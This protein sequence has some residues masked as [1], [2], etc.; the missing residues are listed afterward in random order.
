MAH[1]ALLRQKAVARQQGLHRGRL[2]VAAARAQASAGTWWHG[3]A[4]QGC[5]EFA[6]VQVVRHDL[7]TGTG[8]KEETDL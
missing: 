6:V 4:P 7:H 5:V 3:D 8:A 2:E 1:R